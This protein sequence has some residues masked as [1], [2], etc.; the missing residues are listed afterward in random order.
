MIRQKAIYLYFPEN[1]LFFCFRK[2]GDIMRGHKNNKPDMDDESKIDE[3]V[4][5]N[6][7]RANSPQHDDKQPAPEEV[8]EEIEAEAPAEEEERPALP[9]NAMAAG[10]SLDGL[11]AEAAASASLLI[12]EAERTDSFG[13]A[14]EGEEGGGW[15]LTTLLVT[16]AV[17]ITGVVIWAT[18]GGGNKPPTVDSA[19]QSVSTNED[20]SAQITVNATDKDELTYAVTTA[21]TNGS[22]NVSGN[23]V[24]YSP[25]E[26]FNGSDNL[27]VTVTDTKGQ[28][29]TQAVAI[30]VVA[31]NDAPRFEIFVSTK[32]IFQGQSLS[33]D[34]DGQATDV[35]GDTLTFATETSPGNGTLSVDPGGMF[36]YT[37]SL[38]FV[39]V[40]TFSIEVNDNK[41]GSDV[42]SYVVTVRPVPIPEPPTGVSPQ[43][44]AL[45][46]DTLQNVVSTIVD[47]N[48]DPITFTIPVLPQNGTLITVDE[49]VYVYQPNPNFNGTDTFSLRGTTPDGES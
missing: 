35:D 39:G 13:F 38:E 32:A 33:E 28:T 3:V 6:S 4:H 11:L 21:P 16:G 29:V 31:V 41:G 44:I 9:E 36:V 43:E 26:N 23:V 22:A 8:D 45:E 24:T 7:E 46:E 2:K 37:P 12:V 42:R 10:Y 18:S 20:T 19:S 5:K 49:G 47:A 15:N 34:L 17:V 40:D 48:N 1:S 25:T 30:T 14:Q 27:T